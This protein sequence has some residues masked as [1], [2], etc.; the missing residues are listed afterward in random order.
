MY[1]IFPDIK[2]AYN[3]VDWD[4]I[5]QLLE[6]YG[7]GPNLLHIITKIWQHNKLIPKQNKYFGNTISATRGDR[8]AKLCPQLYLT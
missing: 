4:Q 8:Q 3:T 6:S 5:L 2:K 7:V 1:M